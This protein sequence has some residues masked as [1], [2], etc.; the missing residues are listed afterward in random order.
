MRG[1]SSGHARRQNG[2]SLREAQPEPPGLQSSAWRPARS[3]CAIPHKRAGR[4]CE[5]VVGNVRAERILFQRISS[6]EAPPLSTL[7][8]WPIACLTVQSSHEYDRKF[9]KDTHEVFG[10]TPVTTITAD[11]GFDGGGFLAASESSARQA[12]GQVEDRL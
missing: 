12:V 10:T 11:A 6:S 2:V 4:P 7:A 8:R 9:E 1:R 5:P 3:C